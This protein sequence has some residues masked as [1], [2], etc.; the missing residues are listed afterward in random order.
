[1]KCENSHTLTIYTQRKEV[2]FENEKR[3]K[4]IFRDV[5]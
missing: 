1:M 3:C 2:N 5:Y 4:H